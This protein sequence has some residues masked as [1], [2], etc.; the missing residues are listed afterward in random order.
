MLRDIKNNLEDATILELIESAAYPDPERFTSTLNT[1]SN[2]PELEIQGYYLEEQVIGVIGY[3]MNDHNILE[4]MHIAVLP[5]E[6]LHGFGRGMILEVLTLKE[7]KEII[8]ETDEFSVNFYRSIG[9]T[10][11]SLGEKFPGVERFKCTYATE[12]ED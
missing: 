9:F 3:R 7:P 1:Y 8:A 6:R 4:L 12:I 5:E 2:D 11:E 10:I